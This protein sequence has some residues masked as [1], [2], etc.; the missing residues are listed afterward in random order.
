MLSWIYGNRI[1]LKVWESCA[2]F[3]GISKRQHSK[4]LFLPVSY[5]LHQDPLPR[6][7]D[8][9][10]PTTS[11]LLESVTLLIGYFYWH[12]QTIVEGKLIPSASVLHSPTRLPVCLRLRHSKH[13]MH[14]HHCVLPAG[15]LSLLL[16][17][18]FL[19]SLLR[20]RVPLYT[21]PGF[22]SSVL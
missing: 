5:C 20:G 22:N 13:S 17:N 12:Q 21:V 16:I 9:S 10:S 8:L 11:G 14:L 2:L 3:Y 18:A 7:C 19:I 6:S 4:L 15:A 1:A